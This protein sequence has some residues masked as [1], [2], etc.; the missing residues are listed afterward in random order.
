MSLT[1][2]EFLAHAI[3]L[4]REAADRFDQLADAMESCSNREVG[5]LFRKLANYSRMHLAEARARAGFRDIPEL[6]HEEYK[7]PGLESPETAAIWAADPFVGRDQ[8]LD[9]ALEAETASYQYYK[10]ILDTTADPEIKVFAK[11]FTEEESEHV[12][13]LQNWIRA[14]R[15]GQAMPT[16]A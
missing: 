1:V 13:E 4:E 14:H 3:R 6:K 10:D 12:A 16:D 8:A 5:R 7:W 2:E 11:E 15:L 9:I